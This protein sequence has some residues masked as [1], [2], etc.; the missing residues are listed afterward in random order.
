[1]QKKTLSELEWFLFLAKSILCGNR[2]RAED[3]PFRTALDWERFVA[4]MAYHELYSFF[5]IPLKEAG[6]LIPPDLEISLSR[7]YH[8]SLLN[9]IKAW[10][11]FLLLSDAFRGVN[12]AM[13]PLKGVAFLADVY[14]DHP[15][16]SM[17][18]IDILVKEEEF[19]VVRRLLLG[20]G[21][22]PVN[23]GGNEAYWLHQH[24]ELTFAKKR[25]EGCFALDVHFRL[26]FKRPRT[27]QLPHLWE[28]IKKV[29]ID[30]RDIMLLSPEDQLFSLAL[31]QR[32]FGGKIF[33]LKNILDLAMILKKYENTFDWNYVAFEAR[34]GKME[35]AIFFILMQA[36]LFFGTNVPPSAWKQFNVSSYKKTLMRRIAERNVFRFLPYNESKR[37]YLETHLLLY[38]DLWEPITYLL[39]IPMEQFA[40]YYDLEPCG[41]K[42]RFFY[43]MRL[44]YM[45]LKAF[46]DLILLFARKMMKA[47]SSFTKGR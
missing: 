42:I 10:Q 39:N 28:R 27:V 8:G 15:A 11:E 21:Y 47:E 44:I 43:K 5:Y 30:E 13:V 25:Q 17:A 31:H 4:L 20:L 38:N 37:V 35:A 22:E 7:N 14:R 9:S 40:R 3:V 46:W 36:Q 1:V 41:K 18:D 33:C 29:S 23:S 12:I 34:A 45:P 6:V 19:E 2:I 16:R 32:R 26:D 24:C